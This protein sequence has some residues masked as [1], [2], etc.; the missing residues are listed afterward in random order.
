M[1]KTSI[2]NVAVPAPT[3]R[4]KPSA[5]TLL[6]GLCVL[7]ALASV[8][9]WVAT[10][11]RVVDLAGDNQM[12]RSGVYNEWAK[13]AVIVLVRHAERCD[14]S[15][16][17]CLDDPSGITIAGSQEA[18]NVGDGLETLGL[19]NAK[20][21]SSPE[22]RTRQTAHFM[23]GKAIDTEEW[24]QECDQTFTESTLAHKTPN[25]NLVLVTHSGCI[26]H[27]ERQL[28]VSGGERSSEYASA[29]FISVGANG[30]PRILGQMNAHE[31]G[32]LLAS[33]RN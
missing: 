17:P 2:K 26:D 10:R 27:L 24:I 18:K 1:L 16:N 7:V 11:T 28:K 4:R 14:R 3:R 30:K 5:R 23:F 32:K 20:L 33:T 21:L 9:T 6:I 15:S 13:G 8:T 19:G 31:W 29:L 22:V 12:N 25:Q